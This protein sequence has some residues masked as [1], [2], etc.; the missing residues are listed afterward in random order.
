M[1]CST[2]RLPR[3][4]TLTLLFASVAFVA[5]PYPSFGTAKMVFTDALDPEAQQ[6]AED[7]VRSRFSDCGA[8]VCSK[9]GRRYWQYEDFAWSVDRNPLSYRD[10]QNGVEWNGYLEIY[11]SKY[12]AYRPGAKFRTGRW[13]AWRTRPP[14]RISM[15]K[16]D[17]GWNIRVQVAED[18]LPMGDEAPRYDDWRRIVPG[19]I[20]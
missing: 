6:V 11:A 4:F 10:A 1:S 15:Q 14:I 18:D 19:S 16:T 13:G 20:E 12:R 17:Q 5:L 2:S 8:A 3:A 7:F 9:S